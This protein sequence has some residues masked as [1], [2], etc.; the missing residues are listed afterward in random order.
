MLIDLHLLILSLS[1]CNYNL[2]M[3]NRKY[4]DFDTMGIP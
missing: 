4:L 2:T 3:H 1:F